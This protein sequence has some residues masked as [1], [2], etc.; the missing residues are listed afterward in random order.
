MKSFDGT[1]WAQNGPVIVSNAV[2]KLC[3]VTDLGLLKTDN[4]SGFTVLPIK[5]CYSVHWTEYMKFYKPDHFEEVMKR[6]NDSL[7]VHVWN[8]FNDIDRMI[9]VNS[10]VPYIHLAKQFCPTI[11]QNCGE[12]FW[13]SQAQVRDSQN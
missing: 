2:R 13:L 1:K 3:N 5:S 4:C 8:H 7:V 9:P 10:N 6:V 11:I 12:Y